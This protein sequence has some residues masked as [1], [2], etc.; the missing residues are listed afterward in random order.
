METS[1]KYWIF[2]CSRCREVFSCKDWCFILKDGLK[3]GQSDCL[4]QDDPRELGCRNLDYR[5]GASY[6][7]RVE[8]QP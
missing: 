7:Q 1:M 8:T 5:H 4:F 3:I 2:L 6:F